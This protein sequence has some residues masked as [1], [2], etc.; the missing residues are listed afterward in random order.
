VD[1]TFEIADF[2]HGRSRFSRSALKLWRMNLH[3]TIAAKVLSEEIAN[4]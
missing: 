2:E 1:F 4:N 3:E